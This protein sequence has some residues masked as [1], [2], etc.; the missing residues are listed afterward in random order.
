MKNK[1]Y[2]AL[3]L[4]N[5]VRYITDMDRRAKTALWS[6]G[7][8]ALAMS[9]SSAEDLYFGLRCNGYKA[10]VIT[11]PDYEEP[12]NPGEEADQP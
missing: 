5:S 3:M 10:V 8:P 12:T 11:M 6:P 4:G 2:V 9:R 1:N 7:K